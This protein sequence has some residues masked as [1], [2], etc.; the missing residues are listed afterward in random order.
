MAV[1]RVNKMKPITLDSD[2]QRKARREIEEQGKRSMEDW[3]QMQNMSPI[4]RIKFFRNKAE[5]G[6]VYRQDSITIEVVS[7]IL[8][9]KAY[10]SETRIDEAIIALNEIKNQPLANLGKNPRRFLV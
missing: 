3:R 10:G 4:D 7:D 5:N 1:T 9:D 2:E 8:K 6:I